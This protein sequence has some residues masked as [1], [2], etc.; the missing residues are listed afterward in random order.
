MLRGLDTVARYSFSTRKTTFVTSLF[1]DY[2]APFEK[3]STLK[4]KK[5]CGD[6]TVDVF[7]FCS[8]GPG[9]ESRQ[10]QTSAQDD[11][12]FIALI[13]SLSPLHDLELTFMLKEI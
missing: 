3:R 9:F 11:K 4:R 5:P 2:Q 7:D 10:R 8:E 6:R 12:H 1:C 13:L